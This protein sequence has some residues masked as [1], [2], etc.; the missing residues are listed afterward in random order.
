MVT[1]A[2][3]LIVGEIRKAHGI[4]GE[5][6]VDLATDD[7]GAIYAAGATL[8][9]G[10]REGQPL[11]PGLTVTVRATR[12]YKGGLLISFVD[13]DDRDFAENLRGRTLLIRSEDARPLESGEFFLHELVGLDVYTQEG[14]RVGAVRE[15]YEAAQGHVLGVGDGERE[16]L[17]PFNAQIVRDVDV[18]AGRIVIEPIPG[19]LEA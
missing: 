11:E 3:F 12:P 6:L 8:L 14:E 5:C 10:D 13:I 9:V 1:P 17:V 18:D 19:L 16:H 4:K 2:E 15:V 7:V